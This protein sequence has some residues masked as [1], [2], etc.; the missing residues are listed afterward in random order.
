MFCDYD[1]FDNN[2]VSKEVSV[3]IDRWFNRYEGLSVLHLNVRSLKKN[4]NQLLI[5]LNN[6]IGVFDILVITEVSRV[7]DKEVYWLEGYYSVF[8]LRTFQRGGGLAIFF[9]NNVIFDEI[10]VH[11]FLSFEGIIGSVKLP[12]GKLFTLIAHYRPPNLSKV[13]FISELDQL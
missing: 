2:I 1:N 7:F 11:T 9:K 5:L 13:S 12:N 4:W 6:Q 3:D 10:N 8:K